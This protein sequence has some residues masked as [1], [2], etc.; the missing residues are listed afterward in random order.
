MNK[1]LKKPGLLSITTFF[2]SLLLTYTINQLFNI[3]QVSFERVFAFISIGAVFLHGNL[4]HEKM[5]KILRIKYIVYSSIFYLI[6][7]I[8]LIYDTSLI[9]N[10]I[11]VIFYIIINLLI[12][13]VIFYFISGFISE[14][15]VNYKEN[16]SLYKTNIN[17]EKKKKGIFALIL[18]S[19][20]L[21]LLEI[22]TK[23]KIIVLSKEIDLLLSLLLPMYL[24][25][26][27]FLILS[28]FKGE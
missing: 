14:K 1:V 27:L 8:I 3:K 21:L 24:I 5:S 6:S 20:P 18:I 11:E 28:I 19:F 22:L 15:I 13:G 16:I 12:Q 10:R 26:C 23:F 7:Y 25:A 17:A 4:I 2:I 9:N